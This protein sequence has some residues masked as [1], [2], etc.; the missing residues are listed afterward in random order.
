MLQIETPR[1]SWIPAFAGMTAR[2]CGACPRE[3]RGM[4]GPRKAVGARE[5]GAASKLRHSRA[6]GN[7][8]R[9]LPSGAS[10]FAVFEARRAMLQIGT[11]RGSWIP[12]FAGMTARACG[13]CPRE[14]RGMGGP[15]KAVGARERGAASKLRHSRAS[16]NPYRSLPSGASAFAVFEA[17]RAMLQ[18][19]TPRGSWIP[20]FAGMTARACGACP[21]ESKG[22]GGPRKAIGARGRGA[23][24]KLR[25]S[26]ASGNPCRLLPSGASAF[27]VFAVRRAMLQTRT[28]PASGLIRRPI[29]P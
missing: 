28:R 17:R 22:M 25:H 16:G 18:I 15:R 21:R 2:A 10:A 5:R 19:G 13:A 20:A 6:S 1:G 12:A 8:Y 29:G 23:A 7:P 14:S 3:S 26:R 24:S 9:S 4:G 27:A 11:P